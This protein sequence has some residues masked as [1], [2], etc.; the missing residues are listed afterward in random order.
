MA[1]LDLKE[2]FLDKVNYV[3]SWMHCII[4][5]KEVANI[6]RISWALGNNTKDPMVKDRE[7][8]LFEIIDLPLY[9]YD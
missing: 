1:A 5:C 2:K 8:T 4:F 3:R 9:S 7:E 6:L